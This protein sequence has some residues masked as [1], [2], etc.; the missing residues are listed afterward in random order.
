M[1]EVDERPVGPEP[2]PEF[3]ATDHLAWPF[4]QGVQELER[5]VRQA[6]RAA[7]AAQ[8]S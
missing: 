7:V 6:M 1:L 4:Q 5:L 3:F 8:L 2:A